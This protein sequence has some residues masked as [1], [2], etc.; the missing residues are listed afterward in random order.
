M[1]KTILNMHTTLY[2]EIVFISTGPFLSTS[3]LALPTQQHR[4]HDYLLTLIMGR[5]NRTQY[6]QEFR[7]KVIDDALNAV[8]IVV[9]VMQSQ[10]LPVVI[11]QKM[12]GSE[13]IFLACK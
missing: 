5:Y 2:N 4:Y 12:M 7:L 13:N 11:M 8:I 6:T 9:K 1:Y 10:R 3:S